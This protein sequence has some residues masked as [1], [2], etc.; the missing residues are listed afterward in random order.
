MAYED[1]IAGTQPIDSSG[2]ASDNWLS[3]LTS[4]VG[5]I[6]S[7][8]GS[9]FQNQQAIKGAMAVAEG[10]TGR[11]SPQ[12]NYPGLG[13]S[14]TQLPVS[15][16]ANYVY[17]GPRGLQLGPGDMPGG[18][19]GMM[20]P[21]MPGVGASGSW[22][23]GMPGSTT[24]FRTPTSSPRASAQR[25]VWGQN[26]VSGKMH[27]WYHVGSL[28]MLVREGLRSCGFGRKRRS[29]RRHYRPY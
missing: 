25:L 27:V 28:D 21:A 3:D 29:R 12:M 1:I 14:Q 15:T 26:P 11:T 17:A 5:S 24:F 18:G 22:A 2:G 13:Y 8:I 16:P 20:Q 4:A 23:P 7:G 19:G 6:T 10:A 9:F